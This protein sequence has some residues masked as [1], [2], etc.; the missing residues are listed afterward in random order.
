ML[1]LV[2]L[3]YR[4]KAD[5]NDKYFTGLV[6]SSSTVQ[7]FKTTFKSTAEFTSGKV[8]SASLVQTRDSAV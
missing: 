5:S 6:I 8:R 1:K 3:R 7:T 2:K 4:K